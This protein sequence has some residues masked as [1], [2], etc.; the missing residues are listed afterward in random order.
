MSELPT[1]AMAP[2]LAEP[3]RRGRGTAAFVLRTLGG[4]LVSVGLIV[5]LGFFLFR[6][7][8]GDP[9]RWM[10]RDRPG[11]AE[12]LARLRA[13]FGLDRP[14]PAQFLGYLADL[15]RGDLGTSYV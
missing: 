14:L 3:P 6:V 7:L 9:V 5:A 12:Q 10:T 11:N 8:P 13:E 15:A 4:G 1:T 2:D